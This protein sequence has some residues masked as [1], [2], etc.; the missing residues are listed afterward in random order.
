MTNLAPLFRHS[1]G[2]DRFNDLFDAAL[3]GS[4]DANIYPPHNVEKLGDND[5]RITLAVAGFKPEELELMVQADTL[6][7]SGR[8]QQQEEEQSSGEYL[9]KGIATRA[10][11]RK[12]RLSDHIQV[13]SA[14]LEHGLLQ[15]ELHREV[16]EAS[17]PKVIAIQT[18][19]AIENAA[20][21]SKKKK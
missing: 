9:Y 2:F 14:R 19:P 21:D 16:P 18:A 6:T 12:F 17:K 7:I 4:A 11:Q 3:K 15:I 8:V 10:F 5:Y 20:Q 13:N 1:V